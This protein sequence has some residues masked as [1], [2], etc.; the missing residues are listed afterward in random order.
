M[1]RE[2]D[3]H[4]PPGDGCSPGCK[5]EVC[6][7]G[8]L[9]PNE[10]CDDGNTAA[11][12]G[13]SPACTIEPS[14]G[15]NVVDPGEQCDD[16]NTA[17]SDGCSSICQTEP[18]PPVCGNGK[19]EQGEQCDDGNTLSGD[20][21][22]S[23][24]QAEQGGIEVRIDVKPGSTV[25]PINLKSEGE[26]P[27]AILGRPGFRVSDLDRMTL[28]FGHCGNEGARTRAFKIE[29][30]NRDRIPDLL[31]RYR[32]RDTNLRMGDTRACLVGM[33]KNGSMVHGT[34]VVKILTNGGHPGGEG[35]DG[36]D[37]HHKDKGGSDKHR[38]DRK[39]N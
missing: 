1:S 26:I 39:E 36:K 25:N 23:T 28:R 38:D 18:P 14:C 27:V 8:I 20:G 35:G 17:N 12:D 10:Q 3:R 37:D 24:C 5:V 22:S 21:C 4:P 19:L 15:N 6:G 33:T 30:V 9:D 32:T 31:S 2:R 34:D 16:G 13:C 11:G 7:N 29:D